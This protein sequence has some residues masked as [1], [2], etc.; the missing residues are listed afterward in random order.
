MASSLESLRGPFLPRTVILL[1]KTSTNIVVKFFRPFGRPLGL[2]DWPGLY[3]PLTGG[4]PYPTA[5]FC[6]PSV[7][8]DRLMIELRCY[9]AWPQKP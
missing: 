4:H 7:Q 3:C 8:F 5:P 2:P 9:L 1:A 6:L